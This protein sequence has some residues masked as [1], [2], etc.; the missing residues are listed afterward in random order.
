MQYTTITYNSHT[1]EHH[2]YL[3]YD[4]AIN[5][6]RPAILI[7]PDWSGLNEFAKEKAQQLAQMGYVAFA[8]DM[9]G[10]GKVGLSNDEKAELMQPLIQD[11][12][13]LLAR[14]QAALS[15]VSEMATVDN[16]K[17][18][19][20]GFCFGGLCAL[21]LARSG[22]EIKGV[23]SFHGLLNAPE[24]LP[25]SPIK[26]K[27]LALHGY[28]DPMVPPEQ[29]NQFANEMTRAQ[30]DWQIHMYGNTQHAFTNPAANDT[31]LGT[32]YNARAEQRAWLTTQ[33]FLQEIF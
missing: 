24:S 9:Y 4:P 10:A 29:I 26:A 20:I 18:A 13:L 17:I 1:S 27:V 2:G 8:L 12:T 32:V 25:T 22:A 23:V 19:A 28:A 33:N 3:A 14:M 21:D 15:T 11:R 7:A 16:Q 6:P 5:T 30:A 31:Q